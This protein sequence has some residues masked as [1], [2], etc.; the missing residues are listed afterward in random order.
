MSLVSFTEETTENDIMLINE[1]VKIKKR[2]RIEKHPQHDIFFYSITSF[3]EFVS[4]RFVVIIP[5]PT[6][7]PANPTIPPT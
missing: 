5:I 4:N 6:I 7:T 1:S 3:L 2:C